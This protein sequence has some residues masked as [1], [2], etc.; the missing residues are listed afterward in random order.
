MSGIVLLEDDTSFDYSILAAFHWLL[1]LIHTIKNGIYLDSMSYFSG[2]RNIQCSSNPIT[3]TASPSDAYCFFIF[4]TTLF[5]HYIFVNSPF[6]IACNGSFFFFLN[7]NCIQCFYFWKFPLLKVM[8][9]LYIYYMLLL[10][11]PEYSFWMLYSYNASVIVP[12]SCLQV[13]VF[14]LGKLLEIL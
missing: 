12:S 4:S 14:I 6:F 1:P 13:S 11:S 9:H 5:S 3:A 8:Q 10:F 2:A 7:I